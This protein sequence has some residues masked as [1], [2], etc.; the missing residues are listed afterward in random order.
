MLY[1]AIKQNLIVCKIVS[2]FPIS[3]G[4]FSVDGFWET[5]P[6]ELRLIIISRDIKR[7]I[8]GF[9]NFLVCNYLLGKFFETRKFE[10]Y[11]FIHQ[12]CSISIKLLLYSTSSTFYSEKVKMLKM[13]VLICKYNLNNI[14]KP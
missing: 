4:N 11:Y 9:S 2:Y 13:V 8:I 5:S 1:L 7:A 14:R 6:L 12:V 10:T 3:R